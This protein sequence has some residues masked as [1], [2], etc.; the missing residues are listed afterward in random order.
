MN[1]WMDGLAVWY[2]NSNYMRLLVDSFI[3]NA[4]NQTNQSDSMSWIKIDLVYWINGIRMNWNQPQQPLKRIKLIVL[5]WR[6]INPGNQFFLFIS[7]KPNLWNSWNL[8]LMNERKIDAGLMPA[9]SNVSIP[10]QIN[11]Q[12]VWICF[13]CF[14]APNRKAN[15]KQIKLKN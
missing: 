14:L 1:E 5:G 8:D 12:F 13:I 15:W 6:L 3:L 4:V 11:L 9:A 2:N 7:I 10:A